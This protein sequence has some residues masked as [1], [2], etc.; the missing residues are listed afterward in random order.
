M[1][2]LNILLYLTAAVV[3][4]A[5]GFAVTRR[6]AVHAAC[7]LVISLMGT[8]VLFYLLGA[9]LPAALEVIIYAGGIMVLF[10]FV[11][12]MTPEKPLS[13]RTVSSMKGWYPAMI[14]AG[15]CGLVAGILVTADPVNR[16]RPV[17]VMATPQAFGD[18]LFQQYWFPVEITSLLLIAALVGVLYLSRH[19]GK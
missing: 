12:M 13:P 8:A 19:S 5:T 14:L 18:I 17:A 11:I 15:I 4:I 16:L 10:L 6:Q 3:I 2:L 9:P 1:T 7:Y